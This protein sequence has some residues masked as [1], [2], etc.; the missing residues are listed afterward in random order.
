MESFH[1]PKTRSKKALQ[2]NPI[3]KNEKKSKK[4]KLHKDKSSKRRR[5]LKKK[6]P[7]NGHNS[8]GGFLWTRSPED[9]ESDN[10]E[11][12][13][14]WAEGGSNFGDNADSSLPE[15]EKRLPHDWLEDIESDFDEEG[16][17]N[18]SDLVAGRNLQRQKAQ[19]LDEAPCQIC[20]ISN[21][22]EWL[23]L[24]DS[25]D[26]GYHAQ[27]LRPALHYIPPGDWFCPR[28]LHF[29]LVTALSDQLASLQIKS[30]KLDSAARMQERLNFVNISVSNI[31]RDERTRLSAA[32]NSESS[33]SYS[34]SSSED[35]EISRRPRQKRPRYHE[36][37]T[38]S[39]D[40]STSGS[41]DSEGSEEDDEQEGEE[42]L[43][44]RSTRHRKIRYDV[45]AAFQ[46][47]DEVLVEDE[48]YAQEK[49][50]RSKAK[51]VHTAEDDEN[52]EEEENDVSGRLA[53][54]PS[55]VISRTT[56]KKRLSSS[57]SDA[58]GSEGMGRRKRR[59]RPS[60]GSEEFRPSDES[61][62][63]EDDSELGEVEEE[64]DE[65]AS[66]SLASSDQSW[67]VSSKSR[68]GKRR[69]RRSKRRSKHRR[70]GRTSSGRLRSRHIPRFEGPSSDEDDEE[71]PVR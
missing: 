25:C 54:P 42:E 30:K 51:S 36:S 29:R 61:V 13:D 50:E 67:K 40:G 64:S 9:S 46:K 10:D 71:L 20:T 39:S 23:L 56:R 24:C 32:V 16:D 66:E 62:T 7:R 5:K 35:E 65:N 1:T 11:D 48:K 47:L 53:M 41:E 59:K 27:C 69:G 37:E 4:K 15:N 43:S 44:I 38:S 28:C 60:S 49:M 68:R 57:S 17:G 52:K 45:N 22:P 26:L 70:S 21:H 33:S 3:P 58:F 8:N 31:L 12:E 34:S 55:S 14:L 63:D 6:K 19:V 2:S 18:D